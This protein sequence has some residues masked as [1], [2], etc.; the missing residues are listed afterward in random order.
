MQFRKN[1]KRINVLAYR[2]YNKE[3]RYS[4]IKSLGT[5]D[6]YTLE[7]TV[8]LIN[9]LTEDE[10]IELQ[11]YINRQIQYREKIDIQYI[12]D[13][14]YCSIEKVTTLL[15]SKDFELADDWGAKVWAAWDSLAREMRKAGFKRPSKTSKNSPKSHF[16]VQA[17]F[18]TGK[19]QKMP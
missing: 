8:E 5:L 9:N 2:G 11:S 12:A 7:P 1:G 14:L 13:N 17:M 3:K 18:D 15:K 19:T 6:A 16:S 4:I 10:K